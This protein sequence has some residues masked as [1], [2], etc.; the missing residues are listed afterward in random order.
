[1]RL[2]LALLPDNGDQ[3]LIQRFERNLEAMDVLIGDALRFAQGTREEAQ[4]LALAIL[5]QR[6]IDTLDQRDRFLVR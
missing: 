4:P 3:S 2:A 6:R 5:R 1:M